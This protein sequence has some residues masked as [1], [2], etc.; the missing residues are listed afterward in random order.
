MDPPMPGT[1]PRSRALHAS[2]AALGDADANRAGRVAS[3]MPQ[4]S[5]AYGIIL[6]ERF[7][8]AERMLSHTSVIDS[9]VRV[10]GSG[11]RWR[12]VVPPTLF[13]RSR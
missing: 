4:L 7:I 10:S 13:Q 8:K 11:K 3:K 12:G 2:L 9:C 1:V 6:L 5:C